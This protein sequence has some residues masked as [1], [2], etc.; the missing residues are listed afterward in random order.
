MERPIILKAHEVR[1]ILDGRQTQLRRIIKPQ[2][3]LF[4]HRGDWQPDGMIWKGR[5]T[6]AD[7]S[8]L[9]SQCPFGQVG[10][11]LWARETWGINVGQEC[12]GYGQPDGYGGHECCGCP[13]TEQ[14]PVY[15]SDADAETLD[16]KWKSSTQMPRYFARILFEIVSV[17]VERLQD[18]SDSD[19]TAEGCQVKEGVVVKDGKQVAAPVYWFDEYYIEAT[20]Q[21][22]FRKLWDFVNVGRLCWSNDKVIEPNSW[23]A[24]PWV[25]VV[26]FKRVGAQ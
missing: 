25:W 18:I 7:Q 24:N 11:R 26:E 10:D 12:C 15:K 6:H 9:P 20:P 17:R 8:G 3:D 14:Y 4:F 16:G 2:P 21:W 22:A 5:R 1:G 13:R 19:A 23:L